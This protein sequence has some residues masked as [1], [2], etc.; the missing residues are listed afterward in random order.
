MPSDFL[1]QIIDRHTG[2][3]VESLEPGSRIEV[4]IIDSVIGRMH[5]VGVGFLKSRASVE[6]TTRQA[7]VDA[8]MALKRQVQPRL[9]S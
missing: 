6:E 1:L 9:P 8:L 2:E 5:A 4:D 3:V 7:W